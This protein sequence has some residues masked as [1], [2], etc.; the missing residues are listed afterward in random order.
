MIMPSRKKDFPSDWLVNCFADIDD[1]YRIAPEYHFGI[2]WQEQDIRQEMP[3]GAFDLILCRHL[4]FTY[5]DEPLQTRLL[6]E[7]VSRLRLGGILV[8]GKQE[9]LPTQ[10]PNLVECQPRIGLYQRVEH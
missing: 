7:I 6:G 2:D 5:F 9:S 1:Q 3:H 8:I 10:L 4:A